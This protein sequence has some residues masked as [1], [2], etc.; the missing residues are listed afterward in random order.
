M[1]ELAVESEERERPEVARG[2][3][4]RVAKLNTPTFPLL[5]LARQFRLSRAV[6][7]QELIA[8]I[9]SMDVKMMMS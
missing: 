4:S 5:D 2:G 1:S 3:N 6:R 8:F 9:V 7:P